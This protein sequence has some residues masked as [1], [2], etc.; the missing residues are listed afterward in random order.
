MFRQLDRRALAVYA[1]RVAVTI[2][3]TTRSPSPNTDAASRRLI[4]GAYSGCRARETV[5][6]PAQFRQT[7]YKSQAV[8]RVGFSSERAVRAAPRVE[9][10]DSREHDMDFERA[11]ETKLSR[12]AKSRRDMHQVWFS[13]ISR[14]SGFDL[15][16]RHARDATPRSV[17]LTRR[18]DHAH[19]RAARLGEGRYLPRSRRPQEFVSTSTRTVSR[20]PEVIY[21]G[22]TGDIGIELALQYNDA[23]TTRCLVS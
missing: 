12:S 14:S 23:T 16:I 4:R 11:H 18:D 22:H 5:L 17:F 6:H 21:V 3:E 7:T 1:D 2:H 20:S 19:R 13:P 8:A 15:P 9:Q 10:A